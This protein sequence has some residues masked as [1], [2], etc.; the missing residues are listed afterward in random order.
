MAIQIVRPTNRKEFM[1]K[2][3]EPYDPKYGNPN[4][5]FSEPTKLG[6]PEQNRAYEIS[7]KSEPEKEFN[8]GIKDI[9]EA[10]FY[11]FNVS[12]EHFYEPI[13]TINENEVFKSKKDIVEYKNITVTDEDKWIYKPDD[14]HSVKEFH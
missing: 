6:Q 2:L 14:F 7:N 10:V 12:I 13:S 4:N 1:N 3:V 11:Y 5:V 9:D 8:I